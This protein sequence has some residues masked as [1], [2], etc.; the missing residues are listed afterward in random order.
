[1]IQK[2][3]N[4]DILE[5]NNWLTDNDLSLNLK[6]GKTKTMIFSTSICVKA[7]PLNIQ[8]KRTSINQTYKYFGAHLESTLALNDNFNSNTKNSVPDYDC[9]QNY[10]Q[11]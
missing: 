2:K 10:A 6:K 9:C 1:M 4:V 3:L 5:V 11:I 8:I 7:A